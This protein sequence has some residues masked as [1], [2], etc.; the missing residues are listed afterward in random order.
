MLT[1]PLS[2]SVL[3]RV[4][5]RHDAGSA[6]AARA[7]RT[8]VV[9]DRDHADITP[10]DRIPLEP[11]PDHPRLTAPTVDLRR[12]RIAV[13]PAVTHDGRSSLD[14]HRTPNVRRVPGDQTPADAGGSPERAN[15]SPP[16]HTRGIELPVSPG[17]GEPLD[18][19]RGALTAGQTHHRAASVSGQRRE[20]RPSLATQHDRLAQQID[21]PRIATGCDHHL[22][23]VL[24]CVDRLLHRAVLQ[25]NAQH[26]RGPDIGPHAPDK[27]QYDD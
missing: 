21:A 15:G 3:A 9:A 17:D 22:V 1:P 4:D 2:T 25:R 12:T 6:E 13:E 19:G 5:R 11:A 16:P 26:L 24:R 14:A 10:T 18:D 20:F 27:T 23:A 8:A 7:R